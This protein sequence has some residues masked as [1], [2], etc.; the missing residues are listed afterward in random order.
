[1]ALFAYGNGF[2]FHRLQ[3]GGLC[4]GRG[5]IYFVGQYDVRENGPGLK[6]EDFLLAALLNDICSCD[7]GGHEI[8]SELNTREPQVHHRAQCGNKLRFPEARHTLE[9]DM[10]IGEEAHDHAIDDLL[11]TNDDS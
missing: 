2:F 1:M 9:Q 8:G 6:L 4:L 11:V 10:T 7:V 3:Q 5:A